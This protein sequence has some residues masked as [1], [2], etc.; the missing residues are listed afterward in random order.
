MDPWLLVILA[1]LV[2]THGLETVSSLLNLRALRPQPPAALAGFLDTQSYEKSVR[3]TKAATHLALWRDS[4]SLA[5]VV[6]F[7]ATGGFDTLDRWI[8]GVVDHSLLIGLL[9]VAILLLFSFILDLPFSLYRTFVIEERFGFNRTTASTYLA[10]LLKGLL[11]VLCLGGPL[12]AFV[13]WFFA[14]AGP[15]AW[16]YS[17][18]ALSLFSIAINV[19]APV[20]ILPLFNTLTPLQEGPLADDIG[21]Y[22]RRQKFAI[23]GVYTMDGSKRSSKANAFFTGIGRFRKVV[24]YDTLLARLS[25][26]EIVAVLAH[27]I[28]H[29]KLR[30]VLKNL[31]ASLIQGLAMLWLLSL[32]LGLE[33]ISI[34]FGMSQPS[35][36]ASL[37]FFFIVFT[38]CSLIVSA[39]F[40]AVSRSYEYAADEF[41]TTTLNDSTHLANALKKLSAANFSHLT[42]HPLA[43]LLHYSHPPILARITRLEQAAAQRET[44]S[45]TPKP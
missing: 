9:F 15:L 19:L 28:G 36:H 18:I 35:I 37:I 13:L 8:R 39:C 27:E 5:A 32:F 21:D 6:L 45:A 43:V 29:C 20:L 3:Y 23:Q 44:P 25:P 24:L 16:F 1:F 26:G 4:L 10:D 33:R 14:N 7:S 12:L 38:P 31:L 42:P 40:N 17:W 30:H 41:A 2:A 11:L 34:A 22:A